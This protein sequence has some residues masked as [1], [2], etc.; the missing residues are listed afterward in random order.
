MTDH[1]CQADLREAGYAIIR[2]NY[3]SAID[4]LRS[5]ARD[6]I[7]AAMTGLGALYQTGTGV[8]ADG[9]MAFHYLCKA[10][11]AGD[12]VAAANLAMLYRF[13]SAGIDKDE[14]TSWSYART[15]RKMGIFLC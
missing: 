9:S 12:G 6:G 5:L 10:L 8:E 2:K 7:P 1:P 3:A 4:I 13:G 14:Q 15:A 11:E